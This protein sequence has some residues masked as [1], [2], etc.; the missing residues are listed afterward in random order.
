MSLAAMER[1]HE[2]DVERRGESAR[3]SALSYLDL[4]PENSKSVY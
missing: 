1:G 2:V 3:V 4:E